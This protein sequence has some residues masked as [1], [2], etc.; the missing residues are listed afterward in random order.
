MR[1]NTYP[2]KYARVPCEGVGGHAVSSKQSRGFRDFFFYG[3]HP[4]F[5]GG[6]AICRTVFI[7]SDASRLFCNCDLFKLP[8]LLRGGRSTSYM[9]T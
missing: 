1:I 7:F 2:L 8:E 6:Q 5:M 9:H 4:K 3:T